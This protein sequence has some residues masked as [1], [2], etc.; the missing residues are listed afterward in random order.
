VAPDI[1]F[2]SG[3]GASTGAGA[4]AGASSFFL[5]PAVIT[6]ARDRQSAREI[7]FFIYFHL[8]CGIEPENAMRPVAYKLSAEYTIFGIG[9]KFFLR[10]IRIFSLITIRCRL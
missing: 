4:G 9:V 6:A 1:D 8:F 3:F 10:C 7:S 2:C 5:Q